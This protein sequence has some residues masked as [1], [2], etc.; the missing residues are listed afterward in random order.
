MRISGTLVGSEIAG[1]E[2]FLKLFWPSEK[3]QA[4]RPELQGYGFAG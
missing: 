3:S 4:R 1:M 2:L